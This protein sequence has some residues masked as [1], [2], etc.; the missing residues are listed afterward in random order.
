ML[1]YFIAFNPDA[2]IL[3]R[4]TFISVRERKNS[5][6]AVKKCKWGNNVIADMLCSVQNVSQH[7]RLS[8]GDSAPKQPSFY[9]LPASGVQ[10]YI[11]RSRKGET[12]HRPAGDKT[13]NVCSRWMENGK[14]VPHTYLRWPVMVWIQAATCWKVRY[15]SEEMC[16]VSSGCLGGSGAE[17]NEHREL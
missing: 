6:A 15:G 4:N 5:P 9:Q 12:S 7:L 14:C 2:L 10:P 16:Y 11:F 3:L 1:E 8:A 13:W 17:D